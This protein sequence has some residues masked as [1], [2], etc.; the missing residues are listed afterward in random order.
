MRPR[1]A[2][3]ITVL[4]TLLVIGVSLFIYGITYNP[5]PTPQPPPAVNGASPDVR[6]VYLG[7]EMFQ[8][9]QLSNQH[10]FYYHGWDRNIAHLIIGHYRLH[11]GY[12]GGMSNMYLR[13]G[14]GDV[15]HIFIWTIKILD[16]GPDFI[17][18]EVMA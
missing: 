12:A 10:V 7:D 15:V 9:H 5:N 13:V 6:M 3:Y 14:R 2:I 1:H 4:G 17:K 16:Y 8:S 18:F 11:A